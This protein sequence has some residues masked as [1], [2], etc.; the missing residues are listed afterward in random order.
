MRLVSII[1]P[2]FKK[3]KY[4]NNTIKSIL[5]QSY[6]NYEILI[7]YD[8]PGNKEELD[9]LLNLK[10]KYK[11]IKILVNKKNLGAGLSRNKAIKIA[12]GYY[13]SFLDADD[14]WHKNKLKF[15]I[16]IMLKNNW[17]ISHT[18]YKI[19]NEKNKL[20]GERQAYN[21]NFSDLVKSCDVGLSTV[22]IKKELLKKLKFASL[23]TKEDYVLWLN[24]S[25]KNIF[26]GI[27][28]TLV[29]W[30]KSKN[31]L[32]SSTIRK[33]F[34]GYTVYR[35]YLKKSILRSLYSLLVLSLNYLKK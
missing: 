25:K 12:K 33:L 28:K 30:R 35:V 20:L 11:K 23:K 24:L 9:Y 32:S 34:D 22:L 26:F 1:I 5:N 17:D 16:D 10:K 31:S 19:I 18:S 3:K 27:N 21:L 13:I 7:V 8:D 2:Y 14:F 15:Q 6:S 4:F 29:S